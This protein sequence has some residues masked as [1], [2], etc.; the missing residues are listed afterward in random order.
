M[1]TVVSGLASKFE[2][3]VL[4]V[5]IATIQWLDVLT[6][7]CVNLLRHTVLVRSRSHLVQV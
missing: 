2:L 1:G 6:M 4:A 7:V 3:L 5:L